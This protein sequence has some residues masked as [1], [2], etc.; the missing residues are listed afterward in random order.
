MRS[1]YIILLA[2]GFLGCATADKMNEVSVGMTK[3]QVIENMGPPTSTSAQGSIEYLTYAL[4]D[5][6]EARRFGYFTPYFVRLI[7]GK[8]ESYGRRGD[9]DSTKTPTQ[10]LEI[11]TSVKHDPKSASTTP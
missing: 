7:D 10:K 9:F 8:V 2:F 3:H 5:T 6:A 1:F 4:Y 11:E